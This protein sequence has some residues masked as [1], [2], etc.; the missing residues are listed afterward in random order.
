MTKDSI[1][2]LSDKYPFIERWTNEQGI[3][4]IG[5]HENTKSFIRAY[6]EGG[7]CWDSADAKYTSLEDA[8]NDLEE[9]LLKFCKENG[10]FEDIWDA[11]EP[12]PSAEDAAILNKLIE[13][14]SSMISAVKYDPTTKTLEAWFKSGARWAYHGVPVRVFK[15]L[16]E[17][18]S[19]G[20]Y[21]RNY[22]IGEYDEEMLGK[23]RRR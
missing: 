23:K 20:S 10:L 17:S 21:M 14:D 9:G 3:V 22:I 6:D 7:N 8:L 16:L 12:P 15:E 1:L 5:F 2:T 11:H 13:V 18:D 19:Q 4:E